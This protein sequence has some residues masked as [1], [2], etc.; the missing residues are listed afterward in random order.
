MSGQ[1]SSPIAL[2][3]GASRGIGRASALALAEDPERTVEWRGR[4][5]NSLELCAQLG[6][7][8]GWPPADG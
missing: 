6:L 2:V 7:V 4:T 8:E 3:T 1:Q 5:L